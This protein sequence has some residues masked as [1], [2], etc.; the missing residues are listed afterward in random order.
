MYES[1]TQN[2]NSTGLNKATLRC[3]FI[4]SDI[5]ILITRNKS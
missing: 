4:V 1:M 2:N 5:K 3:P